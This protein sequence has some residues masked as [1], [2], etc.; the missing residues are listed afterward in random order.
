MPGVASD[1]RIHIE[2]LES[3]RV[4][5][6]K[7]DSYTPAETVIFQVDSSARGAST[8]N[9]SGADSGHMWAAGI[10]SLIC[11]SAQGIELETPIS[12]SLQ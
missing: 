3:A 8:T 12:Y 1:Y 5:P 4:I 6:I 7:G 10:G 11:A 2:F 9:H